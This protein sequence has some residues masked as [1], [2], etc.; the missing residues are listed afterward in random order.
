MASLSFLSKFIKV[1]V[2][3]VA[4]TIVLVMSLLPFVIR[5][6]AVAWLERQGLEAE[7]GYINIRPIL[8]S[9]QINDVR[10]AASQTE[11]FILDKVLV[12][13]AW[14]PL[15]AKWVDVERVLIDGVTLD[16]V[17]TPD[18][19]RV[20]GLPLLNSK[21]N[22]DEPEEETPAAS[23]V[24]RLLLSQLDITNSQLCY[25]RE[26][27]QGDITMRQC[28]G[29]DA[30]SL[31]G[32]L[33]LH[34]GDSASA[35]IGG[36]VLTGFHWH[37]QQE[38]A[39]L[40][41]VEQLT[42][43]GIGSDDMSHWRV[44]DVAVASVALL[45]VRDAEG[46]VRAG[47]LLL[48]SLA[49]SALE[50][51]NDSRID[52]LSLSDLQVNMNLVG[53]GEAFF[54]PQL[55][56][57]VDQLLPT[58]PDEK[59]TDTASP[60]STLLIGDVAI[61]SVSI[62][63]DF[64]D[65]SLPRQNLLS[66]NDFNIK[67][68]S[69]SGSAVT[70]SKLQLSD[71]NLLPEPA[72]L[73]EPG[74]FQLTRLMLS[75]LSIGDKSLEAGDHLGNVALS[76]LKL[77]LRE[78]EQGMLTFAPVFM[79]KIA[80]LA[81]EPSEQDAS[82]D[83]DKEAFTFLL[84]N[85]SIDEFDAWDGDNG[86]PLLSFQGF[87]LQK[88]SIMGAETGLGSLKLGDLTIL[89]VTSEQ[90]LVS[91]DLQLKNFALSNSVFGGDSRLGSLSL[92]EL[93]VNLDAEES[94]QLMFAPELL[95]RLVPSVPEVDSSDSS[96]ANDEGETAFAIDD[97]AVGGISIR[98]RRHERDLLLIRDTKL[99]GFSLEGEAFMLNHFQLSDL[100]V[101]EPKS[102]VS[103]ASDFYFSTPSLVLSGIEKTAS[104]TSLK[105]L[106]VADPDIFI[107]R[108]GSGGL[109]LIADLEQM[110]QGGDAAKTEVSPES[111]DDA[112]SAEIN[113]AIGRVNIGSNGRLSV[114]DESVTPHFNKH[115]EGL[116]LSID[117]IDSALPNE[118]STL[119][120]DLKLDK[121]GYIKLQGNLKPFGETLNAAI[122]GE[123]RGLDARAL[124]IYASQYIGYSL[125]QGV[126][127]ADI[128]FAVQEDDVNAKVVTRF[129][130]LEVSPLSQDELPEGAESL[131]V[132]LDFALGLLRDKN[133]MI[134]LKLPING[135]I[136][137]P[138]FSV[139][140]I[141]GKVMFKVISETII[142]YYMPF[143]LIVSGT[144]QDTLS[145]LSFEP[146]KFAPGETLL[147]EA[148]V[149]NLDKLSEM[150]LNREQLTLSFCAPST[151]YDWAARYAPDELERAA[152]GDDTLDAE[153]ATSEE[154][155]PVVSPE[156]RA[157]L[158]YIA[159]QRSDVVKE[160]LIGQGVKTGQVIL[161][162]G[163]FEPNNKAL[164]QMDIAI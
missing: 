44:G 70:L 6:Q 52:S 90:G 15:L 32:N 121:F 116:N 68:L 108:E 104:N 73:G 122:D 88:L 28:I 8:G 131:G 4:V 46:E 60:S 164:P 7:I 162:E 84:E 99:S 71:L 155:A 111:S 19:I 136:H 58:A 22:V 16:V 139:G 114:L 12:N 119:S 64:D 95:S 66:F 18:N 13:I 148:A 87:D 163:D 144:L 36:A 33:D 11:Q 132:P 120:F 134:E 94:G 48:S 124:S 98:D 53:H 153:A 57:R 59:N 146:V 24:N 158:K 103:V 159:N 78:D 67:Q 160:Y 138:N 112:P 51:G 117:H 69:Q 82:S 106:L 2:I 161:C 43:K 62:S 125:D 40:L 65:G 102:D 76:G 42:V 37:D 54:S 38:P 143:G 55:M 89:P 113:Y 137:S 23:P 156:Q 80:Q 96:A 45:P 35:E 83:E 93:D 151:W 9:V 157:A 61:D 50:V 149:A 25:S 41:G 86:Q 34:L 123:M 79:A 39:E 135:D 5:W 29:F 107:Y 49:L 30:F 47:D 91:A 17:A 97:L 1:T 127:E 110:V 75:D 26:D 141:V 154:P 10:I 100:R 81:P 105:T 77:A 63:G 115:Y 74:D 3:T 92:A 21:A 56:V 118:P 85:L 72:K 14:S 31:L 150:L 101:L 140:H 20:G 142:N 152:A 129:H 145:N 109:A 128:D 130:K 27:E 133:G 126:A 147:N